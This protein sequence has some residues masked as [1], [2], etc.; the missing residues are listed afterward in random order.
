LHYI[1]NINKLVINLRN[2]SANALLKPY[3]KDMANYLS[4]YNAVLYYSV[5]DIENRNTVPVL[6]K[7]QP[8]GTNNNSQLM[9]EIA[10]L[11]IDNLKLTNDNFQLKNDK[12]S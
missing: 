9:A 10:R 3:K 6:P 4:A 5:K 11:K 2:D 7:T 1:D 12:Q 8:V